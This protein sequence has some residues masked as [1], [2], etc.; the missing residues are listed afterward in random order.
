MVKVLQSDAR[1]VQKGDKGRAGKGNREGGP[2]KGSE[3]AAKFKDPETGASWSGRGLQPK[4]LK[5]ALADGK[6]IEDFAV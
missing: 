4:W 5:A 6:K 2:V 3:V 1:D